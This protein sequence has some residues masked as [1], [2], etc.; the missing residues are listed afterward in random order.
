MQQ[1]G[2]GERLGEDTY[3]ACLPPGFH[4]L[5]LAIGG[6]ARGLFPSSPDLRMR[7]AR[8]CA[9]RALVTVVTLSA[10]RTLYNEQC[11]R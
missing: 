9:W 4:R 8:W 3:R 7:A 5:R 2:F 1:C 10:A 11:Q 6:V